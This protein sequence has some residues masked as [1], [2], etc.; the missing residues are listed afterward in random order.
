MYFNHPDVQKALHANVTGITYPW[1]TCRLVLYG[2]FKVV[3]LFGRMLNV[4]NTRIYSDLVGSYWAD[5][6]LSMLPIYQELIGAGLRIWAF[7]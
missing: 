7:R 1:S 2:I 4:L 6:P 5:S 3:L